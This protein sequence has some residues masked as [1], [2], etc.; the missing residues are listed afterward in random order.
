MSTTI[1]AL[2]TA[3]AP[4]GIGVIRISGP[5]AIQIARQVFHPADQTPLDRLEGYQAKYGAV[6]SKG[7]TIAQAV[8]LVF[9]APRSY[10]GED[11]VELSCHGSL[12]VLRETLSALLEA[13]A[14]PAQP[15]EFTKR[16]FLNGKLDLTQAESVASLISAQSR[17]AAN[18]SLRLLEGQ[19]YKKL[20]PVIHLLLESS[21]ALGAWVDYPDEEIPELDRET[22]AARIREAE[23]TLESLLDRYDQGQVILQGVDTVI[24]GR[25]NTGKSSL[26]NLLAG[27]EKS[28]VTHIPG[29]T[30]DIIEETVQLGDVLLR[31]SDTAGLRETDNEVESIGIARSRARLEQAG[32]VF[33]VFDLSQPLTNEDRDLA[34]LCRDKPAVAIANKSDLP[35]VWQASGLEADFPHVVEF[36]AKNGDGLEELAR[37]TGQLLN[38]SGFDAAAPV[39]LGERQRQCCRRALDA[40]RQAHAALSQ[41]V[42]LDAVHVIIDDGADALLELTGR[43]ASAAVVDQIFSQFCVG[44]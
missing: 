26:M 40:L 1:A 22:L 15:G 6:C 19:L 11:V 5:Q 3:Q 13:G 27:R 37:R 20:E 34:A 42:T 25:P 16:A 14:E 41:G 8:A 30:R 36:S 29:T 23:G 35:R 12:V 4:A 33:A 44:K 7:Q 32:L 2:A 21:A 17:H 28:I 31:L 39:L 18:A 24:A 10:T 38:L 43:R 9:R